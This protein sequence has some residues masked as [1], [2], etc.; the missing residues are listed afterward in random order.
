MGGAFMTAGHRVAEGRVQILTLK[1]YPSINRHLET[2]RPSVTL[3]PTLH[4]QL[5]A[6]AKVETC[7]P[8]DLANEAVA[9]LLHAREAKA[10]M[11]REAM[12]EAD[13]KGWI[14]GEEVTK[15]FMSLGTDE[16]LP[17]PQPVKHEL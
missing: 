11:I 8:A 14:P 2:F 9:H 15:W 12:E 1:A 6:R 10:H 16:E 3:D 17:M 7:N 4:E 5:I 13:E